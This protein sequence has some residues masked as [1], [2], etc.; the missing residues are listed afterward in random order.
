MPNSWPISIA[1]CH[2]RQEPLKS[3]HSAL[4]YRSAAPRQTENRSKNPLL[5]GSDA[6]TIIVPHVSEHAC[7]KDF[8]SF[9]HDLLIGCPAKGPTRGSGKQLDLAGPLYIDG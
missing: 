9:S 2:K 6:A 5:Q 4:A 8:L 7:A 1:V 3:L